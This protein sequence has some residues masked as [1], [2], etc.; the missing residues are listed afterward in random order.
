MGFSPSTR[1]THGTLTNI[2]PKLPG[3]IAAWFMVS[4]ITK[5]Y[6]IDPAI[7]GNSRIR[8]SLMEVTAH[9]ANSCA[10]F[11]P[12]SPSRLLICTYD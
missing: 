2:N 1:S 12:R 5:F 9:P 11:K 6:T 3:T 10:G 8:Q 7:N 4:E